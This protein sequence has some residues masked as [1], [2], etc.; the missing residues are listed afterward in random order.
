MFLFTFIF[1]L[2]R[3]IF[4]LCVGVIVSYE[5]CAR[6]S[7]GTILAC[8]YIGYYKVGLIYELPSASIAK[9]M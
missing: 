7:K 1:L 9:H 3:L 2:T 6:I 8:A 4:W 5:H